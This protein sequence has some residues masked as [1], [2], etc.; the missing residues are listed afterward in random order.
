MLVDNRSVPLSPASSITSLPASD[1]VSDFSDSDFDI[2]SSSDS[3]RSHEDDIRAAAAGVA[4]GGGHYSDD[5]TDDHSIEPDLL[6]DREWYGVIDPQRVRTSPLPAPDLVHDHT[7]APIPLALSDEDASVINALSQSLE[8]SSESIRASSTPINASVANVHFIT[9]PSAPKSRQGSPALHRSRQSDQEHEDPA[10]P[11]SS[12][13]K[14]AFPDPL[15]P[16]ES[17]STSDAAVPSTPTVETIPV[18][19]TEDESRPCNAS[20]LR[21]ASAVPDVVNDNVPALEIQNVIC[22]ENLDIDTAAS[23]TTDPEVECEPNVPESLISSEDETV[24]DADIIEEERA[25]MQATHRAYHPFDA[26]DE[27]MTKASKELFAI[28][29]G[30]RWTASVYISFIPCKYLSLTVLPYSIVSILALLIGGV[31]YLSTPSTP[32]PTPSLLIPSSTSLWGLLYPVNKSSLAAQPSPP[33]AQAAGE[34]HTGQVMPGGS[35]RDVSLSL[36]APWAVAP[37]PPRGIEASPIPIPPTGPRGIKRKRAGITCKD[38]AD[39]PVTSSTTPAKK[40]GWKTIN[41]REPTLL[42]DPPRLARA[43][44]A[45]SS[46]I[47]DGASGSKALANHILSLPEARHLANAIK[48]YVFPAATVAYSALSEDLAV[49]MRALDE[50]LAAIYVQTARV[51]S[52]IDRTRQEAA[53]RHSRAKDKARGLKKKSGEVVK[54]FK[55]TVGVA[56]A[57]GENFKADPKGVI[58]DIATGMKKDVFEVAQGVREGFRQGLRIRRS[59][60]GTFYHSGFGAFGSSGGDRSD[61]GMQ[62][63]KAMKRARKEKERAK[64]QEKREKRKVSRKAKRAERSAW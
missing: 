2:I 29:S 22:E 26:F 58:R 53:Y 28:V 45:L 52:V 15:S 55:R 61:I 33:V 39:T 43:K 14:L 17:S 12:V 13:L 50:L 30:N 21:D 34:P 6:L 27:Y 1:D 5:A 42:I 25:V 37:F 24:T 56:V 36:F 41:A 40:E 57:K 11:S 9:S 60:K 16:A 48:E 7:I 23:S 38:S 47:A 62:N 64:K 46:A 4:T 32:L 19:Q 35:L 44:S 63:K 10:S 3:T 20:V 59:K 51:T 54:G 8:R 31:T 18:G 49:L